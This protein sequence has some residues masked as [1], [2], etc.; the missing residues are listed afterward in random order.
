MFLGV[1]VSVCCFKF[2]S[3]VLDLFHCASCMRPTKPFFFPCVLLFS[4][5]YPPFLVLSFSGLQ[6]GVLLKSFN[7]PFLSQLFSMFK[8]LFIALLYIVITFISLFLVRFHSC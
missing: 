4:G 2:S 1:I 5:F 7:C 8:S 6:H 3:I